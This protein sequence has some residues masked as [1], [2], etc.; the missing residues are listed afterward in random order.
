MMHHLSQFTCPGW[1]V[2]ALSPNY[3]EPVESNWRL[4]SIQANKY[5]LNK[6]QGRENQQGKFFAPMHGQPP[7]S[8]E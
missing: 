5:S 3:P 4:D 1:L 6:P 2:L 8:V 7:A